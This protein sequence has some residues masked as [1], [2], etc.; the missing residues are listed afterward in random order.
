MQKK[1]SKNK[2]VEKEEFGPELSPDD[3]DIREDNDLTEE[4]YKNSNEVKQSK[5]NK[6]RNNK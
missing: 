3:L 5:S 6:N 2:E 1:R 4:Q